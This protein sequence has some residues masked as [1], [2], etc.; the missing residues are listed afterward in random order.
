MLA[1]LRSDGFVAG[2]RGFEHPKSRL[3]IVRHLDGANAIPPVE[4]AAAV[5]AEERAH[6]GLE[7]DRTVF[8]SS[9]GHLTTGHSISD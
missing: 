2:N 6:S 8:H 5:D 7:N 4:A 1:R 3:G 9:H